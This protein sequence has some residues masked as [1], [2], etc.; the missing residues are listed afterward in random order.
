[1]ALLRN[2][3]GDREKPTGEQERRPPP[4]HHPEL[5]QREEAVQG[6]PMD[7][8]IRA[9]VAGVLVLQGRQCL[10]LRRRRRENALAPPFLLLCLS[11]G[12]L[13]G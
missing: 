5:G 8:L 9:L 10:W 6:H 3:A 12:S 4:S 2:G 7:V 11:A 13:V 1:M